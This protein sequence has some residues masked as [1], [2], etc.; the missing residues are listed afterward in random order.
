MVNLFLYYEIDIYMAKDRLDLFSMIS[1]YHNQLDLY[2][3][4]HDSIN[5]DSNK[6]NKQNRKPK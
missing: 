6:S 5:Y 3:R 2:W 4:Y 1:R